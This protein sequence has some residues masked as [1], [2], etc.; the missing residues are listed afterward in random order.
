MPKLNFNLQLFADEL[1]DAETLKQQGFT[2]ED[3]QGI[4][5]SEPEPTPEPVTEPTPEPEP[6]IE[7]TEPTPEPESEPTAPDSDKVSKHVPYD[8]FKEIN[9]KNKVLAAEIAALKAKQFE[10]A[11]QPTQ[12]PAPAQQPPQA[13]INIEEQ[14]SKLAR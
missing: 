3:L 9:D 8:R 13:R 1:V 2:D 12:Q 5:P 10:P 4:M 7:T 14:I 6:A 11:P